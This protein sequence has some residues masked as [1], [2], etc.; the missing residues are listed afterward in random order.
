MPDPD[1]PDLFTAAG[2][3]LEAE[4]APAKPRRVRKPR[5][6]SPAERAAAV[7]LEG[8]RRS[9][10]PANPGQRA[11]VGQPRRLKP[12]LVIAF[13]LCRNVKAVEEVIAR[14]PQVHGEALDA[15]YD[16]E[17]KRIEKRLLRKGVSKQSAW[18]CAADVV[19]KA[20]T[21]TVHNSLKET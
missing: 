3:G 17:A 18:S 21:T 5:P 9:R 4:P 6:L 14:L 11:R 16:R 1:P 7:R 8:G 13:P 12:A 15:F 20:Y 10:G 19:L 2:I